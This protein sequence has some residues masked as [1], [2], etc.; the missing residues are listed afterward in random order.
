MNNHFKIIVPLYNAEKW[1]KYCIASIKKQD[2]KNFQC[3]IVDDASTDNSNK[4]IQKHISNDERF[5]LLTNK[6]NV[7]A[8]ENIYNAIQH[9]NPSD[10][11]VIIN[12]DGDDW[13]AGPSVLTT[14]SGYYN[15]DCWLTYGSHIEYPTGQKSKF[16][17]G[18]VPDHI[19]QKNSYRKHQWMTS[20]LRTFKYKLWKKINVSDLK[21]DQGKFYEAAWDLAYMFPMLEMSG[22][23]AK[24]VKE[25]VYVYN[26]HDH[27]DH[28]VPEKRKKQ[29]DYEVQIRNKKPYE[30]LIEP[31]K[32]KHKD[33]LVVDAARDLL[34]AN[35]FDVPAKVLYARHRDKNV[36]SSWAKQVYEHHLDVWGGFKEKEPVKNNIDDFYNSFHDV[37]DSIKADGFNEELS[38]VPVTKAGLLLNGAHR[39]AAAIHYKKPVVCRHGSTLEGQ[40]DC[41]YLYFKNKKD[42]VK[43]G[44]DDDVADTIA[45]EYARIKDTTYMMT[46]Y[47][48]CHA[49]MK[50]V[51]EILFKNNINVVYTKNI[52]F[53]ETGKLN[54]I[55]SLYAGESWIG[56][57][58]NNF[59]GVIQQSKLSFAAGSKIIA[60]LVDVDVHENLINAKKQIREL[61]GVGKPSVHTTDTK[62]ETW[63][64]ATTCF[65]QETISY[66]NAAPVGAM[67]NPRF[68]DFIFEAKKIIDQSDITLEDVCVV[69][70]APLA[71]YG[72]RDCKDFDIFHIPSNIRFSDNVSSHNQY[73]HYYSDSINDVIY[74]PKKHFY[75]EGLKF[76]TANGMIKMKSNRSENKDIKDINMMTDKNK[77]IIILAAGP[78]KPARNR[79]LEIFRGKPLI[80]NIIQECDI[81]NTTL[82]VV[83]SAQNTE[84]KQWLENNYN[85]IN[86]IHPEDDKVISTFKAA[87]SVD[88][89]CIMVAGDLIN[90]K[91]DDLE[92]FAL[93]SYKSATCHYH[94]PWGAHIKSKKGNLIRRADVGDCISMISQDHKKQFLSLEN[95]KR[96]EHLFNLF[97][98]G[99]NQYNEM[100]EYW[101]NDVGTFMSFA[102]FENIWSNPDCNHNEDKGAIS[103]NKKIY[104]DND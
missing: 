26:L 59:P 89:D 87:L 99:G 15:G 64:N 97:Y 83:I 9:S 20:A 88:G 41:S 45:L 63:R 94:T 60:A 5:T 79:H 28:K 77:N 32:T 13:L 75:I 85:Q 48:H 33:R 6:V 31:L 44:L 92:K 19:I 34:K 56:N 81:L 86:I 67:Y 11:D 17:R 49:K 46:I 38:C 24:Y 78:P 68:Q 55:L 37:L 72:K 29:L 65:N 42:I 3:V 16:C 104:E 101:Y 8:L 21:N 74:H 98:P 39:T 43:S 35:R 90:I 14:L 80:E 58:E 10:E 66:I 25:I 84:L 70:S 22:H 96:A 23:K 47:E 103:F 62:D 93:S 53:T 18:P 102:F 100:N 52:N 57:Y 30:P 50:Q 95:L 73:A 61:I 4:E 91:K 69:G 2:Y 12:L 36:A 54:Y 51:S 1:V 71:A 76:I 7:G 82:H 40:I 27:N